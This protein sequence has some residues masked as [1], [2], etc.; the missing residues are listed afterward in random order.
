MAK[1]ARECLVYLNTSEENDCTKKER[2]DPGTGAQPKNF[3]TINM[4]ATQQE[5]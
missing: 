3:S 1:V 2:N 5:M 4:G